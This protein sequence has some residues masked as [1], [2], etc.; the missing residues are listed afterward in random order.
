MVRGTFDEYML[1]GAYATINIAS[2]LPGT[3]RSLAV[4]GTRRNIASRT[5]GGRGGWSR[6]VP[7]A[8]APESYRKGSGIPLSL[9]LPYLLSLTPA[10]RRSRPGI[11][12]GLPALR[13]R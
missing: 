13:A 9:S 7:I 11:D 5:D 10:D 6:L 8:G 4:T 12:P 2:A 3:R 1:V